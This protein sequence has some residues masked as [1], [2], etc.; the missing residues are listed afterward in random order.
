MLNLLNIFKI[1]VFLMFLKRA[2]RIYE[3]SFK[4][5]NEDVLGRDQVQTGSVNQRGVR[6]HKWGWHPGSKAVHTD[7]SMVGNI[8]SSS[9]ITVCIKN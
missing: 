8:E 4:I 6:G 5:Q 2:S 9:V 7:L 1:F 3:L